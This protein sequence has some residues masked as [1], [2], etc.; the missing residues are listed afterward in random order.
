MSN[1]F[2]TLFKMGID[3]TVYLKSNNAPKS[4]IVM[5]VTLL[6]QLRK[7]IQIVRYQQLIC[8]TYAHK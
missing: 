6:S 2:K 1:A 5:K 7:S 3:F 8:I 4:V